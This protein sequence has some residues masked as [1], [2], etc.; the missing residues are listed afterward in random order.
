MK[1][2]LS[3]LTCIFLVGIS[4]VQASSTV[5]EGAALLVFSKTQG[6]RHKSI[7]NGKKMLENI[8]KNHH[9]KLVFSEDAKLF[10]R[11]TLAGFDA[12][13]FLNTTGDVLNLKQQKAFEDYIESG[14]GFVGVHSA[15]DTEDDWPWYSKMLGA[16]F[17]GHSMTP[18]LQKAA[19]K[20]VEKQK[21]H[22]EVTPASALWSLPSKE[23]VF[24]D[25]WYTFKN[26][27]KHINPLFV[28][29][30]N[31]FVGASTENFHP[32]AWF[33]RFKKGRVF[34]TGFGHAKSTYQN[35]FFI[36]HLTG[37][38][39]YAMGRSKDYLNPVR[40]E[41][42]Q[43]VPKKISPP[44]KGETPSDAIVLFD[45]SNLAAWENYEASNWVVDNGVLRVQVGKKRKG[46]ASQIKTKQKFGDIQLHIEWK[47]PLNYQ[48]KG[49]DK[50][51]SGVFFM[52]QFEVQVLDSYKNK[53]YPNGQAGSIYKQ[54]IP[55][56]NASLPPGEWQ[57]Y[58]IVF[59]APRYSDTY[60]LEEPAKL[61]VFH[62]GVLIHHN[63][64]LTGS[65]QYI[66]EPY[67]M[68][69]NFFENPADFE[70]MPL[71]LQDHNAGV[72][73]RN[74]WVRELDKH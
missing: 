27:Q 50:G 68:L 24:F 72:S 39:F 57:S 31:S 43:P 45:G 1:K 46:N 59:Y 63:V 26:I 40:T 47:T 69:E 19:V 71:S 14:G 42:W 3:C 12:V 64:E 28:L 29:D 55:M 56:V 17:D 54:K 5:G 7:E 44:S 60:N 41:Q 4:S 2:F 18:H 74:I 13:L 67:Y 51:N 52:D 21:K 23:F 20:V 9:F 8:A 58:D 32:I 35:S 49:Q 37:G 38:I 6:Y 22:K 15:A 30:P 33:H 16:D 48:N 53:T 62:N 70:K 25:E 73:Y 66:A 10:N 36:R 34:Y 65:T 61:T 11:K